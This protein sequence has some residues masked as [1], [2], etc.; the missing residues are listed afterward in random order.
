MLGVCST[1]ARVGG[2]SAPW[3]AV[4]LPDQVLNLTLDLVQPTFLGEQGS[5]SAAVPLYIFGASSA[6]AGL[7]AALCLTES[8]GSPLPN[9]FKVVAHFMACYHDCSSGP[10][11]D[12]GQCQA[13]LE[14]CLANKGGGVE[15]HLQ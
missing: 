15:W 9:T 13:S 3:I 4:Y 10:G 12:E 6:V 11:E 8:L 5:L 7:L 1:I 2:I 14:M